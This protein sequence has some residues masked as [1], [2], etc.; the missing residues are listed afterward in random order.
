MRIQ[1]IRRRAEA[2]LEGRLPNFE[3]VD[4][5]TKNQFAR[6]T[7]AIRQLDQVDS[8]YSRLVKA[9]TELQQKDP[10]KH[11]RTMNIGPL[12]VQFY[13]QV[14]EI[15]DKELNQEQGEDS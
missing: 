15:L 8:K 11:A 3:G 4:K 6:A 2:A 10:V 12:Y 5:H 13:T 7:A 14:Q 9:L 1:R